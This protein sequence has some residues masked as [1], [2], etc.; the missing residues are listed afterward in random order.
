MIRVIIGRKGHGKTTLAYHMARKF[1][2]LVGFDP[3]GLIR[4]PGATIAR[5][6]DSFSTAID[7]LA[8]G[9][10]REVM[11]TPREPLKAIAFPHFGAE[12]KRWIDDHRGALAVLVDEVAFVDILT[13]DFEWALKCC[14]ETAVHFFLTCHRPVDLPVDVRALADF[15]YV[16]PVHQEHDLDV[17]RDRCSEAA[18]DAAREMAGRC[19]VGWNDREGVKRYEDP[20]AWFVD[21]APRVMLVP[22]IELDSP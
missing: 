11:Y 3:R 14:D 8:D 4:R 21:L 13:E 12:V 19:F 2:R 6:G 7:A 1:P 15:W 22:P 17:I 10:T 5:T 9:D 20:R 18:A 16:F